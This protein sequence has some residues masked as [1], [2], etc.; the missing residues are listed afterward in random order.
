MVFVLSRPSGRLAESLGSATKAAAVDAAVLKMIV[1]RV[2]SGEVSLHSSIG[3]V[4]EAGR[5]G[6]CEAV[7][8]A[9]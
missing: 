1:L 9:L 4:Y 7:G 3:V 6:S 5:A 8:S 2:H